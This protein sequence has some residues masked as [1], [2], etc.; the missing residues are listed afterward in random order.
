MVKQYWVYI[1]ASRSGTLYLG[2]TN[3]LERRVYEH[4]SGLIQ[5]FSQ[6][7]QCHKLIYFEEYEDVNQAIAREKQLKNWHR[8]WK[9]NLIKSVNPT[10]KDL[11]C[12][13]DPETSSG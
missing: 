10:M 8:P 13:I 11:Y 3:N 6:K 12:G 4:K 1:M 5:G 2:I 7:Y 9:V